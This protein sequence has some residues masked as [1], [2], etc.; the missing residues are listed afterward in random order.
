MQDYLYS[1][2]TMTPTTAT[3]L[4]VHAA[5]GEH[6]DVAACANRSSPKLCTLLNV[7][8]FLY[9]TAFSFTSV[10]WL[11]AVN[12][13]FLPGPLLLSS[14]NEVTR[15]ANRN[16][17]Y[18]NDNNRLVLTWSHPQH[19]G[20]YRC[21]AMNPFGVNATYFNI[22]IVYPSECGVVSRVSGWGGCV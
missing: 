4:W 9:V 22:T 3:V 8:N 15:V 20:Q 5:W 2:Q 12:V 1:L 6:G 14:R 11:H 21:Y 13:C 10:T 19:S 18:I 16:R 7:L 17:P